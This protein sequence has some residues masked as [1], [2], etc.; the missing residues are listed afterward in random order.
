M[1]W[2]TRV[3][4]LLGCKYPILQGALARQGTWQLAAAVAE[5]GAH[6][7]LTASTSGS[8]E[9][10]RKDIKQIRKTTKGTFGVNISFGIADKLQEMLAVCI[11]E[12]VQIETSMYKPDA[13]AKLIKESGLPWIHKVARIKDA[14]YAENAGVDAV[15]I[16]GLEGVGFK[17]PEQLPTLMAITIGVKKLKIPVIA[18]GGIG[19]GHGFLGALGMGAEGIMMGTG[20]M[21][22]QES[23]LD[24]EQKKIIAAATE[25]DPELYFR[26]LAKADP[27][28]Y[29]EAMQFRNKLPLGQWLRMLE[30]VNVRD[31]GWRDSTVSTDQSNPRRIVGSLASAVIDRVPTC[32]ELVDSI[33]KEAEEQLDKWQFLKMR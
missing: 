12:G 17:N 23:P 25:E 9:Q 7:I 29:A 3:T 16:V 13:F 15:I 18:A 26:V 31:P 28:E 6:G 4:E 30:R 14:V 24:E 32:K 1:E 33:I 21:V 2:K 27:R 19:D 11:D 20:F 5:T 8:P 22:C 10:L